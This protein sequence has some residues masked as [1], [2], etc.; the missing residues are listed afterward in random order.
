MKSN[1]SAV[2]YINI[3]QWDGRA[4]ECGELWTLRKGNGAD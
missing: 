1:Q 3:P 4:R 2:T